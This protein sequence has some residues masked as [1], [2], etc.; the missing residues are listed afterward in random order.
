MPASASGAGDHGSAG[1][2]VSFATLSGASISASGS[3]AR[4]ES[5]SGSLD[6][7][8]K[9]A[10]A[11]PDLESSATRSNSTLKS[12][13]FSSIVETTPRCSQVGAKPGEI[14]PVTGSVSGDKPGITSAEYRTLGSRFSMMDALRD[15]RTVARFRPNFKILTQ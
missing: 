4:N 15:F 7:V 10:R 1:L 8:K 14:S 9:L 11:E 5:G 3:G 2:L 12:V 13:A 6:S